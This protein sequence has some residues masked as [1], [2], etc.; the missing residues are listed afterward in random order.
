MKI[1]SHIKL[2]FNTKAIH[3]KYLPLSY[4]KSANYNIEKDFLNRE[5]LY[6]NRKYNRKNE[7]LEHSI[8][9]DK[10]FSNIYKFFI[11]IDTNYIVY[12]TLKNEFD[13][14]INFDY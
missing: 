3:G 9:E 13:I 5:I 1:L 8:S 2:A 7:Y 4:L 11:K 6:L 10:T 14:L 12:D